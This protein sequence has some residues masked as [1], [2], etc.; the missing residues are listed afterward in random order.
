LFLAYRP[1]KSHLSQYWEN[2]KIEDWATFE[3]QVE[4]ICDLNSQAQTYLEESNTLV[5]SI[6]EKC[7]IQALERAAPDLPMTSKHIR[8]REFNYIRHGT[9][10]LIAGI[11]VATGQIY[12]HIGQTRKEVDFVKFIEYILDDS[13][14]QE[15]NYIFIIDQLN[16]HKSES[17]VR[18]VA[19][20]NQDKQDLGVKGKSGILK[21]MKTRMKYL[22]RQGQKV[23]FCFTPKHCSWLNLIE[24]WFSQLTKRVIKTGSFKSKEDL[25]NKIKHY[26]E[27]YNTHLAKA[28]RWKASKKKE[29][30]EI[31]CKVKRYI[32]KLKG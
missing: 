8:K 17:L 11:E 24:V 2:A 26:L 7:G 6:D 16:I 29:V 18:L 4:Q 23:T 12:G 25:A 10:T 1:L 14:S 32:A 13:K 15:L 20:I 5:I 19:K 31:I 27:Y 9:Q 3:Q 21:N 22:T 30:L 28:F